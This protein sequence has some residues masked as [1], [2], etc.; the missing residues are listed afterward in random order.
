MDRPALNFAFLA[1]A[2]IP[3][4]SSLCVSYITGNGLWFA[5][6]GSLTVLF[7]AALQ[8][9]LGGHMERIQFARSASAMLRGPGLPG[10]SK[11][12]VLLGKISVALLIIGTLVWGYGDLLFSSAA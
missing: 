10:P 5:R 4:L 12:D 7:A 11:S 3:L 8:Y 1:G 2:V 9:R 6:S